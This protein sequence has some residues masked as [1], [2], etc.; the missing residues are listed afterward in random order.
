MYLKEER[1]KG[2]REGRRKGGKE[3]GREG[4]VSKRKSGMV[5]SVYKHSMVKGRDR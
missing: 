2:G 3:E 5:V 1:G 4:R